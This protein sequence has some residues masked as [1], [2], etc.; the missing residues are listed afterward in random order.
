[1]CSCDW[2]IIF[3]QVMRGGMALV[4]QRKC[5]KICS[6]SILHWPPNF[7]I[8]DF[9]RISPK[10]FHMISDGILHMQGFLNA[11]WT[12]CL[13][14]LGFL[15]FTGFPQCML[16]YKYRIVVIICCGFY[17]VHMLCKP[18]RIG[19]AKGFLGE[20]RFLYKYFSNVLCDKYILQLKQIYLEI[21]AN[22]MCTLNKYE[23]VP[24]GYAL[25]MQMLLCANGLRDNIFLVCIKFPLKWR[26]QWS[27]KASSS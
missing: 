3:D 16:W 7:S 2:L 17:T 14:C 20:M 23:R 22:I 13:I 27:K 8:K 6:L 21:W 4:Y 9:C 15:H 25:L 24:W 12:G 5:S 19:V 11:S 18:W 10:D 1:M 26:H